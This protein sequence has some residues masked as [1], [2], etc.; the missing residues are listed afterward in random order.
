QRDRQD[1]YFSAR[2][3]VAV[4]AKAKVFEARQE[5]DGA[6]LM[7]WSAG[8]IDRTH[9]CFLSFATS[10]TSSLRPLK[11]EVLDL[12]EVNSPTTLWP[13]L[14]RLRA[15]KQCR[16]G[17]CMKDCAAPASRFSSVPGSQNLA[18]FS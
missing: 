7:F 12:S 8:N 11:K 9:G 17:S 14:C 18:Y 1:H 16:G 5:I 3:K 4:V 6:M 2:K 15:D 10:P 13:W